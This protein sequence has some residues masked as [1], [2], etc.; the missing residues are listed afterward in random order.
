MD[1]Q[2]KKRETGV[3]LSEVEVEEDERVG[4]GVKTGVGYT[5]SNNCDHFITGLGRGCSPNRNWR[6]HL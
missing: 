3:V 4:R 5:S 2:C 6:G 1:I